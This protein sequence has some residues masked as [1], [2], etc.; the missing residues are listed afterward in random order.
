[1]GKVIKSTD[2]LNAVGPYSLAREVKGTLYCSGTVPIDSEKNIVGDTAAEQLHQVMKNLKEV[3]DKAGYEVSDIVKSTVFL[4][5]INDYASVNEVY[6]EYFSEPF[7]ARSA[8][9]VANL[10]L[11]VKIELEVIA[12]KE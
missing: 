4:D 1:M 9:E 11:G 6:A 2:N 8:V 12:V 7:P 3:L 5:D 10:P